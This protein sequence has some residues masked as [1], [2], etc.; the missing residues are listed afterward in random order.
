MKIGIFHD[1]LVQKGGA[2]RAVIEL[3]NELNADLITSGFNPEL[4]K[5]ID[6]KTK[7]IDIGNASWKHSYLIGYNL[8]APLRFFINR[9]S[10]DYD[11]YIFSLFSSIFA[12]KSNNMN[13]WFC[14][15]PNRL[16]YDLRDIKLK[17][18]NLIKKIFYYIYIKFFFI[19][20]QKTINSYMTKIVVNSKNVQKRV[21]KYYRK[22]SRIIYPP[23]D[24]KQFKFK[25]FGDFYLSVSRL[26]PEKRID[27]IAK[28]FIKMPN[29]KLVIVG[30]GSEKMKIINTISN[31]KNIKLLTDVGEKE[32]KELYASCLATIYMPIEEDFGLVPLEGM[33]SGKSCIAVN[34]GGCKETVVDGKTGF[35][36][37]PTE[38]NIIKAVGKLNIKEA[39]KMKNNCLK[40]VK[41]FDTKEC[42]KQWK[43]ELRDLKLYETN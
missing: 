23:I 2:E 33:A 24:T 12:A 9:N 21:K 32:L 38:E 11:I 26:I 41:R 40:W 7:V 30:D 29:K 19:R 8:E 28:A 6:I 10:F 20:D 39:K 34:E 3:A 27:L 4:K 14:H 35:L 31:H 22:D 37:N 18:A 5:W 15:T 16:L 13:I 43:K 36:I 42:I 17:N 1:M 25:K